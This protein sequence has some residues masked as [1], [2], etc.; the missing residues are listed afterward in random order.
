MSVESF[1]K[2]AE[3]Y[4]NEIAFETFNHLLFNPA[5]R[6]TEKDILDDHPSPLMNWLMDKLGLNAKGEGG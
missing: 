6:L 5:D 4:E 1:K 2:Q 3:K